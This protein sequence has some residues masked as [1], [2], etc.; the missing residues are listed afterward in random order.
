M[1]EIFLMLNLGF[2]CFVLPSSDAQSDPLLLISRYIRE[3]AARFINHSTN[4]CL[5]K[6]L[7]TSV[8]GIVCRNN[9]D[10]ERNVIS[11]PDAD[12]SRSRAELLVCDY[13]FSYDLYCDYPWVLIYISNTRKRFESDTFRVS[14]RNFT[15]V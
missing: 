2:I 14:L 3:L 8:R 13:F 6:F 7:I 10:Y 15:P 9:V 12:G 4:A 1:H 5:D 11:L